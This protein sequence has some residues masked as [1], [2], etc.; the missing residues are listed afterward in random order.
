MNYFLG[1]E[2]LFS[3]IRRKHMQGSLNA[4]PLTTEFCGPWINQ[5]SV[6]SVHLNTSREK[7]NSTRC[8]SNQL[9]RFIWSP[10]TEYRLP[11][12]TSRSPVA[13]FNWPWHIVQC[14]QYNRCK[15]IY[16]AGLESLLKATIFTRL[17]HWNP[18]QLLDLF[19]P[20]RNDLAEKLWLA[21]ARRLQLAK[22]LSCIPHSAAV[23]ME[24]LNSRSHD[25]IT[26]QD[27]HAASDDNQCR[28]HLYGNNR[29]REFIPRFELY[30]KGSA[31]P[32]K[33]RDHMLIPG[34]RDAPAA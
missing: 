30:A 32:A 19:P 2:E 26:K 34:S 27:R 8:H 5:D 16:T 14:R 17:I 20:A 21:T 23:R 22:I 25:S 13:R 28:G 10:I 15:F 12:P 9:N 11:F 18:K 7:E 3:D 1:S 31:R 24:L 33:A 6:S 4:W 29:Y